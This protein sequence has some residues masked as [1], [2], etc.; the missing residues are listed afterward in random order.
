MVNYAA[1]E[2]RAALED[3]MLMDLTH[4]SK[5]LVQGRDAEKVLN[6]SLRSTSLTR[7][8]KRVQMWD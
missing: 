7:S 1:A 8:W 5:V 4:M 2:H 6:Q 3:V